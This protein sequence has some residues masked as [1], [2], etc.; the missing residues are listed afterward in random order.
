MITLSC[1]TN[2]SSPLLVL[3]VLEGF[4]RNIGALDVQ[5]LDKCSYSV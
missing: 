1:A 3:K 2:I 5:N 4:V